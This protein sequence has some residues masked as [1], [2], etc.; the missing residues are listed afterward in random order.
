MMLC[1]NIK[2]PSKQQLEWPHNTWYLVRSATYLFKLDIIN[3][4]FKII[5]FELGYRS[6]IKGGEIEWA[7]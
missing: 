3:M 1:M 5:E 2:N 4:G 7:W 6:T